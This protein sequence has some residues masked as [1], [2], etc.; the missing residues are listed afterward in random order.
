MPT[1]CLSRLTALLIFLAAAGQ[2]TAGDP[3][4]DASL[5]EK[6]LRKSGTVYVLPAESE[7]STRINSARSLSR[8]IAT[9]VVEKD[10]YER[11]VQ[12]SQVEMRQMEQQLLALNQNL[13]QGGLPPAQNN[14]LVGMINTLTIRLNEMRR[15]GSDDH[16]QALAARLAAGREKFIQSVLDLR[17]VVER[18]NA[19]YKELAEDA[20]VKATLDGLN[21]TE[22]PK[23]PYTLGPSRSYLSNVALLVRVEASVLTADVPLRK[24]GGVYWVDVTF[25]GRITRPMIFD[26]GASI[27]VLPA[28]LAAQVGL[29][30]GP[31]APVMT[32]RVAD[33]SE[34]KAHKMVVPSL[35]VG[36]FTV[37]NVE[38]VVMPASKKDVP[39]LLGQ[40]FQR[41]F[42][43]KFSADA[44]KLVLTKV[45]TP[46][47]PTPGSSR[48][49]AAPRLGGRPPV[50]SGSSGFDS[51]PDR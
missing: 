50:R 3:P 40:T 38:C 44:G 2:S 43:I 41:N 11:G 23:T 47:P 49:K 28:A 51:G 13:A 36:K 12:A 27:V 29:T 16:R 33:G 6:G 37:T 1:R 30:P 15:E 8:A 21:A 32:A 7:V 4:A 17:Q 45:D 46:P 22:T 19:R 42:S 14:Q 34:V 18:T 35:R 31:D 39:P 10:R 25:N 24:E 26:T 48:G 9:A 20:A 5:K